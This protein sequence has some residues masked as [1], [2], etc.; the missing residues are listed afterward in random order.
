MKKIILP[1]SLGAL[2]LLSACSNDD[3]ETA[4]KDTDTETTATAE[5]TTENT[6]DKQGVG[7]EKGLF[8]V[9]VTIPASFFEGEDTEQIIADAKE[10]GVGEATVNEDGS[11][12]YKMS[13]SKH[14]EMMDELESGV[15]EYLTDINESEDFP[16]IKSASG[17]KGYSEFTLMVDQTAYENSMDGFAIFG[18][19]MLGMYYQVFDGV[20]ADDAKVTI[21][22]KDEATEEVF[23]TVV[24]PDDLPEE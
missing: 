17:N 10:E 3:T 4:A 8:N 19:G 12:T 6:E 13:K 7:V 18:L 22:L 21:N 2:L 20:N 23:S 14:K 15:Q 16:S 5:K 11:V 1:V 9:E 24:Y